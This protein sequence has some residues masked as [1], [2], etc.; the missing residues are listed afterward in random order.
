MHQLHDAEV[1]QRLLYHLARAF[2]CPDVVYLAGPMRIQEF[3]SVAIPGERKAAGWGRRWAP[4][5]RP[6]SFVV[7]L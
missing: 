4:L 7:L 6:Y 1:A 2:G 3:R 5:R